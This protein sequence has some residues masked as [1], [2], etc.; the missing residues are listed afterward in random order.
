MMPHDRRE[1]VQ[2]VQ[3][4]PLPLRGGRSRLLRFFHIWKDG[5]DMIRRSRASIVH[6]H[7]SELIFLGL[8]FR[9]IGFQV[10]YDVHEDLPRAVLSRDYIPWPLRRGVSWVCSLIERFA[11]LFL[12]GIVAATPVIAARFPQRKTCLVQNFPIIAELDTESPIPYRLRPPAFV[13]VGDITVIKGIHEMILAI[14]QVH[15][16]A[17]TLKLAGDF[18]PEDLRERYVSLPGWKRTEFFGWI[19]RARVA[20]VLG[21]ARAGM[22]LFHPEPNHVASQPIK[23]FEYMS[24]ALPIIGSDFPLWREIIVKNKCGLLVDPRDPQAI[25][26]AM[27]WVLDHPAEAEIMG[28]NGRR[29]VEARYNWDFEAKK[30]LDFYEHLIGVKRY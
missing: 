10:I 1:T 25:A 18:T 30:L 19:S 21:Q 28:R 27:G 22:V 26:R 20:H 17:A 3:I 6:F 4:W 5:F 16:S 29:C 8:A 13:Y 11:R 24:A 2:G 15:D 12:S 23:L 7:D 14:A 9:L